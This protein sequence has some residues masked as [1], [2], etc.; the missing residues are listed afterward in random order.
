[1]AGDNTKTLVRMANQIGTFFEPYPKEEAIAGV[2]LHIQKFW[3]P[4]MR[5][6]ML[7]YL[8]HGG[9][10][11]LPSVAEAFHRFSNPGHSPAERAVPAPGNT[12]AMASDAG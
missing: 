8:D 4:S 1:M 3:S 10:G 9:E 11:V 6:D 7:A 12:G 2:Q 5:R